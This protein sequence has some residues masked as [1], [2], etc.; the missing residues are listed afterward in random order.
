MATAEVVLIGH[1][2]VGLAVDGYLFF[3]TI[4]IRTM[5]IIKQ[6]VPGGFSGKVGTVIGISW[7]RS[8]MVTRPDSKN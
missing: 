7:N 8:R 3:T 2:G 5:G 1:A 4:K 6:G